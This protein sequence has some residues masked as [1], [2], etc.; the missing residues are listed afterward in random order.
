M[1]VVVFG[2]NPGLY[3]SSVVDPLKNAQQ[4]NFR[5]AE[6]QEKE[7]TS[8]GATQISLLGFYAESCLM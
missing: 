2:V 5:Q 3:V 4:M 8:S 1:A 6:I 7:A